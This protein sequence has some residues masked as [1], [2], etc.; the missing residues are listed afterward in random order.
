MKDGND[1]DMTRRFPRTRKLERNARSQSRKYAGEMW[2]IY[3]Y[4]VIGNKHNK[5]SQ[6]EPRDATHI[7]FYN[8][9][10]QRLLATLSMRTHNHQSQH[11]TPWI[12]FTGHSRSR[13]LG[14]V[15][16]R[17]ETAYYC[18]IMWAL[19][20]KFRRKGVLSVFEN[21]TAIRRPL[22]RNSSEY[23]HIP[24]ISRN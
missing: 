18:I 23:P 3:D 2:W 4:Q 6:E 17:R 5:K 7:E 21:T 14:S 22:S 19:E 1:I 11:K 9:S 8:K 24:Y 10:I 20:S 13:I 16:S 12:T 15:K